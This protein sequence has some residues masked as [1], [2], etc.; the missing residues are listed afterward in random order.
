MTISV[1]FTP[2]QASAAAFALKLDIA[3]Q[4]RSLEISGPDAVGLECL[5]ASEAAWHRIH[6]AIGT[7]TRWILWERRRMLGFPARNDLLSA[8]HRAIEV[9]A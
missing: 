3:V 5:G 7:P 8:A 2:H 4:R 6:R 1:E 9:A